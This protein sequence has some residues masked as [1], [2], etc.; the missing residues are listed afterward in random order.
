MDRPKNEKLKAKIAKVAREQ[1]R[2]LGY[3]GTSYSS[4][5]KACGISR[6]LV[7]YHFP[8]KQLLAIDFME[9]VLARSRDSLGLSDV[10]LAGDFAA[11]TEVGCRFFEW[12]LGKGGYA[13]FLADVI[14]DRDLTGE[15][16]AFN[17]DWALKRSGAASGNVPDDVMRTVVTHMGGFYELLY[18]CL[19]EGLPFDVRAELPSVVKAFEDAL[20]CGKHLP[21]A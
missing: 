21:I 15:V 20:A 3:D 6:N 1:F 16:L 10:G 4:I 13:R 18:F 12:L 17:A 7:Q 19:K 14:R 2:K 9:D 5:A 8:K 11:I